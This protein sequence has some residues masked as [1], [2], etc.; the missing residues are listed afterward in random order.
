MS[1]NVMLPG[2]INLELVRMIMNIYL[3]GELERPEYFG[4]H[5]RSEFERSI[6]T[7]DSAEFMT[8]GP[9]R[10]IEPAMFSVVQRFFSGEFNDFILASAN[11]TVSGLSLIHI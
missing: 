9:G 6:V 11:G 10:F 5:I 7:F 8:T 4:D 2:T 1:V 3:Y